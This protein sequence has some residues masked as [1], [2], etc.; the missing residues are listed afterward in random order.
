MHHPLRG[1]PEGAAA[2]EV[3]R[4]L[5][6]LC[7]ASQFRAWR[8]A[9]AKR[10]LDAL[11][12]EHPGS[13]YARKADSY[14]E[15]INPKFEANAHGLVKGYSGTFAEDV[16]LKQAVA[17]IPAHWKAAKAELKRTLGVDVGTP[18]GRT[19]IVLADKA[20]SRDTLRAQ[21]ET[22]CID[23]K[24]ATQITFYTEFIVVSLPGFRSRFIHELKHAIFRHRM[25]QRNLS[26]PKWVKEGLAVYC[27]G[28][29]PDRM[30]AIL[31]GQQFSGRDPHTVANGLE[32]MPHGVDDYPED[33]LAFVWLE[34]RKAGSVA[35]FCKQL[36]SGTA[37]RDAFAAVAGM[38]Y[39]K[40][41]A[42]A[43]AHARAA[44]KTALGPGW[45]QLLALRIREGSL[46][47]SARKAWYQDTGIQAYK[48]W[49]I[50][51]RGHLLE[52]N[53]RYRIGQAQILVGQ[54][55]AGRIWLRKVLKL[56][57]LRSTI[58]DDAAYWIARSFELQGKQDEA[59]R[60]FAILLRDYSW[61]RK[62]QQA[63]EKYEAAGPVKK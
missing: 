35:L 29:L 23:D 36:L 44:I 22:L 8:F 55:D 25:G 2:V 31:G 40:A 30:A 54:F 3:P 58:C 13:R 38:P 50:K 16:R 14:L 18:D 32:S 33:A 37:Y 43:N 61:S 34:S 63:R 5:A 41:V 42:A 48:S 7:R 49:M 60:A 19:L 39:P 6:I 20:A 56:D 9:D 15:R 45:R 46:T 12:K 51:H 57:Q 17:Q 24:I 27:A 47:V 21:G 4:P 10:S 52:P 28:Q 1:E 59:A 53:V 26:L 11:N 62:A